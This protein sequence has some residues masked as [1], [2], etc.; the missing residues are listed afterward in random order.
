[1]VSTLYALNGSGLEY[2]PHGGVPVS[3]HLRRSYDLRKSHGTFG[4]ERKV[5]SINRTST[6]PQAQAGNKPLII[7]NRGQLGEITDEAAKALSRANG[8]KTRLFANGSLVQRLAKNKDGATVLQTLNDVGVKGEMARAGKWVTVTEK[9]KMRDVFPPTEVVKDYLHLPGLPLPKLD[10]LVNTPVFIRDSTGRVQLL[11]QDGYHPTARIYLK[12]SPDLKTLP[13]VP[14]APTD[15]EVDEAKRWLLDELL[16]DFPFAHQAGKAHTI[17][18]LLLPFVRSLIAGPTPIHLIDAP[19]PGSGKG[20]LN[21]AV[22]L[23]AIGRSAAVM[24]EGGSNDEYRK[25]NTSVLLEGS[26]M[27]TIDNV[28]KGV[29]SGALAAGPRRSPRLSGGTDCSA[30]IP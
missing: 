18:Y 26:P 27:I 15:A 5:V 11:T 19:E 24:P 21:D 23:T 22:G 7:A 2:H 6:A 14:T 17:A 8:T 10:R 1:M 20:L 25:Q 13:T 9:G 12:K 28:N 3:R 16:Y 29:A 30:R 4:N